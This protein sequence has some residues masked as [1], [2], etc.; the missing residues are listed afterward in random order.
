MVFGGINSNHRRNCVVVLLLENDSYRID[1]P[2]FGGLLLVLAAPSSSRRRT[3]SLQNKIII[4][5]HHRSSFII[6]R[7]QQQE[8]SIRAAL[9]RCAICFES[10]FNHLSIHVFTHYYLCKTTTLGK[11]GLVLLLFLISYCTYCISNYY[12]HHFYSNCRYIR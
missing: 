2:F 6:N 4:H 12:Y 1:F 11:R 7:Q 3:P 8:R 10:R 9:A 5:Q